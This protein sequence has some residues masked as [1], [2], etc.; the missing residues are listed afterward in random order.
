MKDSIIPPDLP[1]TEASSDAAEAAHDIRRLLHDVNNHL[2][3]V[4]AHLD[5]LDERADL[6]SDVQASVAE[7]VDACVSVIDGLREVQAL[8]RR[9][10]R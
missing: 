9:F 3:I 6:P 7:A 10:E 2:G 4:V 8:A 1:L 5:L